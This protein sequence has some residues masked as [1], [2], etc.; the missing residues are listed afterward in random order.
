VVDGHEPHLPAESADMVTRVTGNALA[1][2]LDAPELLGVDVQQLARSSV[3]V[4]LHG[5]D[6][7]PV[8]PL[9]QA[10]PP[11]YPAHSGRGYA[12]AAGDARLGQASATQLDDGQRL[13]FAD[14]SGAVPGT[15]TGIGQRRL[16]VNQVPAQP[17]AGG[18]LAHASRYR[19][20]GWREP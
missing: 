2:P 16:T 20:V 10:C 11:Q 19:G 7:L 5:F 12:Q 13:G 18:R 3:L 1:Q 15:G 14:T 9:R 17:L 4:A 6:R 8:G